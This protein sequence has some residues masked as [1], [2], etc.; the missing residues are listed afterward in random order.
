MTNSRHIYPNKIK[1]KGYKSLNRSITNNEIEAAVVFQKKK[2]V[3][4]LMD[5]LLNFMRPLKKN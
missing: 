1:A 3:Q 4:N 2:K 5:L